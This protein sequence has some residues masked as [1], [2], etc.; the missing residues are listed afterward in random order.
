MQ[1]QILQKI[2]FYWQILEKYSNIKS[3]KI[4]PV[5]AELLHLGRRTD[6]QRENDEAFVILRTQLRTFP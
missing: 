3:Y 2:E 5:G 1:I 4:R 6:R